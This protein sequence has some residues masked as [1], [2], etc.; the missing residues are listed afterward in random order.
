MTQL[1]ATRDLVHILVITTSENKHGK[2]VQDTMK[3]N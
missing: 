1:A 3:I 2:R